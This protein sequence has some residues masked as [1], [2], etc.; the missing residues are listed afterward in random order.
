MQLPLSPLMAISPIDGRYAQQTATL[1]INWNEFT[2]IRWRLYVEIKWLTK[3][4]ALDALQI[5]PSISNTAREFL[6]DL[7]DNFTLADAQAIKNLEAT[8]NHDVKA[9][10]YYLKTKIADHAELCRYT[11][12]IHFACTSEDINNLAYGLMLKDVLINNIIPHTAQLITQLRKLAHE[13]ATIPMLA[14]THGQPATP[15]TVGKELANFVYRL[16]RQYKKLAQLEILGKFNG[17]TGNFNAHYAAYPTIDWQNICED[18]VEELGLTWNP[19][20]TQIEPHDYIA[21]FC[22]LLTHINTIILDL[23]RDCWGYIALGYFKQQLTASEVGSSTMPHKVNPIDFENS[24]GNLGI[25]NALLTHFANKLPISRWQRDLSDSTVMRNLGVAIAHALLAYQATQK[26]LNKLIPDQDTILDDLNNH[27]EILT[28]AIQT[29]MRRHNI[30]AAYEQLKTLTRGRKLSA[31]EFR[32]LINQLTL[33]DNIKQELSA[34][35]PTN[36]LGE[37]INL[38]KNC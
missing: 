37:A 2:L 14:R 17:A 21:E 34:L 36:Y 11:S 4:A 10:E 6:A 8:T 24:E 29:I 9:V 32:A 15:T 19:Y 27:W 7:I 30:P 22:Q 13:Y 35:N 3:L 38:A 12:L 26:G 28:E 18:F 20:T 25:A 5:T 23:D 33:P 1:A 16:A 31:T